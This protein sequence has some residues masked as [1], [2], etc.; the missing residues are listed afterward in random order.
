MAAKKK[1]ASFSLRYQPNNNTPDAAMINYLKTNQYSSSKD[2][3]LEALRAFYLP[4]AC[5]H[6]GKYSPEQLQ[7]VGE[8]AIYALQRQAD[9]ISFALKLETHSGRWRQFQQEL[10]DTELADED[11]PTD[12]HTDV[13]TESLEL[14]NT[15]ETSIFDDAGF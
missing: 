10:A 2:L 1:Q 5:L 12:V 14:T 4:V 9:Y 7:K 15:S 8:K 6:S 11:V 3:S 13:N